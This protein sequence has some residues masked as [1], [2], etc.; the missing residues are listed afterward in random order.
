MLDEAVPHDDD[1]GCSPSP[2]FFYKTAFWNVGLFTSLG[3][4]ETDLDY[5]RPSFCRGFRYVAAL[6]MSSNTI[7]YVLCYTNSVKCS[8]YSRPIRLYCKIPCCSM[9]V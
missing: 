2:F 6:I 4:P 8:R 7:T 9:K 1:V 5:S 3:V